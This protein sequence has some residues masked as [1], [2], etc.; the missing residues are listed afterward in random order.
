MMRTIRCCRL[1][2]VLGTDVLL[3]IVHRLSTFIFAVVHILV[4][5]ALYFMFL[6]ILLLRNHQGKKNG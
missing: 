2:S 4:L 1:C 6:L 3:F 5:Y